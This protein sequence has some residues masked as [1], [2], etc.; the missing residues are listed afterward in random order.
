MADGWEVVGSIGGPT[1]SGPSENVSRFLGGL[2]RGEVGTED[3]SGYQTIYGGGRFQD[4]SNHPLKSRAIKLGGGERTTSAAG[5]YQFQ[6]DTWDRLAKRLGLKDFSPENQDKAA[7]ELLKEAGALPDIEAGRYEDAINKVKP[8][9]ESMAQPGATKLMAAQFGKKDTSDGWESIG[10]VAPAPEQPEGATSVGERIG[11]VVRGGADFALQSA[12]DLIGTQLG[13]AEAAILSPLQATGDWF[14]QKGRAH[15]K[16]AEKAIVEGAPY[17]E[18]FTKEYQKATGHPTIFDKA[19]APR[20]EVGQFITDTLGKAMNYG[21]TALG[22]RVRK[23]GLAAFG[24]A[25]PLFTVTELL[26][27]TSKDSR[28]TLAFATQEAAEAGLV[29]GPFVGGV[30]GAIEGRRA[31]RLQAQKLN[32]EKMARTLEKN[33]P[34]YMQEYYP[35]TW[36]RMTAGQVGK[37]ELGMPGGVELNIAKE[38]INGLN[39]MGVPKEAWGGKSLGELIRLSIDT[40]DKTGEINAV[41]RS[42]IVENYMRQVDQLAGIERAM[43]RQTLLPAP[44]ALDQP[45]EVTGGGRAGTRQQWGQFYTNLSNEQR[46]EALGVGP[47]GVLR[48]RVE[49]W[50]RAKRGAAETG[51]GPKAV[52]DAYKAAKRAFEDAFP[53]GKNRPGISNAQRA[54]VFDEWAASGAPFM[55]YDELAK[56]VYARASK[57][58]A[59]MVELPGLPSADEI[60]GAAEQAARSAAPRVPFSRT[61][62]QQAYQKINE[63]YDRVVEGRNQTRMQ[64]AR[65][66]ARKTVEKVFDP[67]ATLKSLLKKEGGD[68]VVAAMIRVNGATMR[69]KQHFDTSARPIFKGLNRTEK[70]MLDKLV[71]Q[72]IDLEL[73]RNNAKYTRQGITDPA[74]IEGAIRHTASQSP[75]LFSKI[76][77]KADQ[78]FAVYRQYLARL[79]D[80]GLLDDKAFSR[81]WNFEWN[82]S[83]YYGLI[84]PAEHYRF[85]ASEEAIPSSGIPH[86]TKIG[87]DLITDPRVMLSEHLARVENRIM[88]NEASQALAR[89]AELNKDNPS[90]EWVKPLPPDAR[91]PDGFT[92]ITYMEGGKRRAIALDEDLAHGYL[93]RPHVMDSFVGDIWRVASG[94]S[95]LKAAVVTYNPLWPVAGLPLDAWHLYFAGRGYSSHFPVFISQFGTDLIQ[96]AKD[97]ITRG[98]RYKQAIEEGMGYDFMTHQGRAFFAHDSLERTMNPRWE[99]AKAV[100]SWLGETQ[101]LWVRLAHRERLIKQGIKSADATAFARDRLDF[102]SGGSISKFMEN[103]VAYSNVGLV[104]AHSVFK[105][106]KEAPAAMAS[107]LAWSTAVFLGVDLYNALQDPEGWQQ[108]PTYDKVNSFPIRVPFLD[109]TDKMGNVRKAYIPLRVD[110]VIA[111]LKAATVA[112]IEKAMFDKAPDDLLSQTMQTLPSALGQVPLPPLIQGILTYTGNRDIH[113]DSPIYTGMKVPPELEYKGP[114]SERPTSEIMKEIGQMTGLSPERLQRSLSSIIPNNPLIGGLSALFNAAFDTQ[115]PDVRNKTSTDFLAENPALRRVIKFTHP[116]GREIDTIDR[117]Q[118]DYGGKI[119]PLYDTIDSYAVQFAQGKVT[120]QD[121]NAWLRAQPPE[122]GKKLEERFRRVAAFEKVASKYQMGSGV[123]SRTWWINLAREPAEVRAQ[124]FWDRWISQEPEVRRRME[125]IA[126]ALSQQH[127]GFASDEFRRH[128][129][130]LRQ[131]YTDQQR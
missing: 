63:I 1:P 43:D 87:K 59:G 45:I 56:K 65:A 124:L 104:A 85:G 16:A 52:D 23:Q 108:I 90:L 35:E 19:F 4:F 100:L 17:Q 106:G 68:D 74:Q 21:L 34:A 120:L 117:A 98:P 10:A 29:L 33:V 112:T 64:L 122:Y 6:R 72:R 32:A 13:V 119:K 58:Q 129:G 20:T 114:A 9:W 37:V 41:T 38:V 102:S 55:P 30:R 53:L 94:M 49:A 24:T 83:E 5:A 62:D 48:T 121:V 82:K 86:P 47:M 110:Q 105:R 96:V 40:A 42:S 107:K 78:V 118:Q 57:K 95:L 3:Q 128:F 77:S 75:E 123:P 50:E 27:P 2:R 28:D 25:S 15:F 11:E 116:A 51:S 109:G 7:V 26:N 89:F 60:R 71:L 127:I 36:A 67:S 31:A 92:R 70:R 97:A 111:P 12:K 115:A 79:K 44:T 22:D 131:Q 66:L 73:L 103:F 93:K 39:G 8:I 88:R 61:G 91:A 76:E 113:Y 18:T 14:M 81:L 130:K 69:A 46:A 125:T 80:R 54:R 126:N 84:D 99:Q 101:E